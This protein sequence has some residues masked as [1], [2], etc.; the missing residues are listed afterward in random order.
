MANSDPYLAVS[1]D[2]LHKDDSGK[3]GK[4]LWKLL[5]D[6]IKERGGRKAGIKLVNYFLQVFA[7][8]KSDIMHSLQSVTCWP[9][10]K[11]LGPNMLQH[12]LHD[13]QV[14]LDLLKVSNSQ[15]SFRLKI[16]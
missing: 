11:H 13:G 7:G 12:D 6:V 2:L 10:L 16:Y 1:Y 8:I 3:W 14:Y 15:H 5:L 4:H 9:G